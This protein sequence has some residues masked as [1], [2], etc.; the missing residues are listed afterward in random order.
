MGGGIIFIGKLIPWENYLNSGTL[1]HKLG[2]I[3][4][5][6]GK[7][8]RRKKWKL[9]ESILCNKSKVILSTS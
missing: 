4:L 2:K 5:N 3:V 6:L 7:V 8:M 9:A 1:Y